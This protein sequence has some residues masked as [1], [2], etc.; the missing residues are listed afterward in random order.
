MTVF[1]YFIVFSCNKRTGFQ[2]PVLNVC[3]MSSKLPLI[4]FSPK[5]H[6]LYPLKTS[7]N[8]WLKTTQSYVI[9]LSFF[10]A[11]ST[12][13][14]KTLSTLLW[15]F[16]YSFEHTFTRWA[17]GFRLSRLKH[18]L[19]CWAGYEQTAN[20]GSRFKTSVRTNKIS[21]Q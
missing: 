14:K 17:L 13:R 10:L 12:L 11:L 6:F 5:F 4:H 2:C 7:E 1:P 8:L 15:N 18:C 19:N 3:G 16:I 9:L 21:P 20:T